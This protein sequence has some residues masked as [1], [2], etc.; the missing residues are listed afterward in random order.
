MLTEAASHHLAL[1]RTLRP[2]IARPA[3]SAMLPAIVAARFLRR[4]ERA[5]HDPFD[6]SLADP[7]P[8]QSWRLAAAALVKRF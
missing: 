4:L 7:D 1:A 6:H 8:L 3:L 2:A 5:G